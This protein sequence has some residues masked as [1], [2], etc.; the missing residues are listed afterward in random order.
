SQIDPIWIVFNVSENEQ[1]RLNRAVTNGQLTL[2]RDNAYDV[3]VKLSDGST[4]PKQGKINFADTRVNPTTGTYEMRAEIPNA[5][6]ALKPGQF[7]RV[8]LRGA[9]RVDVLA[10][11]QVAVL[12]GPQGKFV[13]VAGKK[14][15]KDV[16]MP[17]PVVVGDW[18]AANGTNEWV[19]D[20]GLKPGDPVIVNG[21]AKLMPG[22]PINIGAEPA[23][24]AAPAT[25]A[26]D[27]PGTAQAKDAPA[28]AKN[29]A[30]PPKEGDAA[31]RALPV[32]QYPEIAPPV[33]TVQAV[34]PGAS[35][36]TLEQTV[37]SPIE[38]SINGV[39]GMIYMSSSSA[40]NGILQIQVTF[41]IG[42]N[43][44]I[45]S[46]NVNNRVNAV[47]P[48][49]PEE[50]RRQGVT[51]ERGSSSFLQVLA[52]YSPDGRYNDLFTSN[53]VNLNVLD[54]LK[55]LPGTTNVQIFGAHDYAMRIWLK[56]DRMA[57]LHLTATDVIDAVNE[58]NAQFAAGKLGQSPSPSNQA[59]VYTITAQGRLT[60]PS[61]FEQIIVRANP[62]GST[63][64]LGD[65]A[66]VEL[67]SKDY[68][69]IGRINGRDATLVGVFLS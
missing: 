60:E 23:A 47:L 32:A 53:Y 27:P 57:Q 63:V 40:S 18:V 50:V 58:Q 2:P 6:G 9:S 16:A 35:A 67:G 69:F 5:D 39:P 15:G 26:Q 4:F 46:V 11:P 48:R 33:V 61:Q 19:I 44:D 56:P 43:V 31:M 38:N 22:G 24:G 59:L 7:V 41:D 21:V 13:Y 62:D 29:G 14:D 65:I 17:R 1:L 68:E 54:A 36:Q 55:R 64:R 66:R 52:F 34:Y 42:T 28:P 45:A 12:D 30:A 3:T 37:A 8:I 51:V 25:P 49:L 10:V 20:S